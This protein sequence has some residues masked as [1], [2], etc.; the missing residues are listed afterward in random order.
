MEETIIQSTVIKGGEFVIKESKATDTFIPEELNE[1]QLM[2]K[3]TIQDFLDTRIEPNYA[4]I[5]KQENNIAKQFLQETGDLGILGAHIPEAYGGM[6]LST[7][8][9]TAIAEMIGK[10]G[11]FSVTYAAHTGIGMLPILYYGTEMQ[12]QKYLPGLVSGEL[13]AAYC[14]TEPGS[15]S[16]ALAAKSKAILSEDGSYYSITGQKNVDN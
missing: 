8:T 3:E 16:D 13:A 9:N 1:D 11:S 12:K 6:L 14:L 2:I 10:A 7:N 5:E 4:K 15:G